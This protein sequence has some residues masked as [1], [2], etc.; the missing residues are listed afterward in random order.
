MDEDDAGTPITPKL[1]GA[2]Y[3]EAMLL[4]DEARS[5]FDSAG[6]EE[7]DALDPFA[8]VGFSCESLKLTT[9]LMHIIAWL[10]TQRAVDSGELSRAQAAAPSRRLGEE[11]DSD[12]A[13]LPR[14][15]ATAQTLIEASRDLFSRIRRLDES[16]ANPAPAP[17]PARSLLSRLERAF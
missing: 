14:L 9:R 17:S 16:A 12:E 7:R 8:R 5:Y 13:L 11:P 4:A 6:R 3:T 1:I 2:L 10:L 15:P